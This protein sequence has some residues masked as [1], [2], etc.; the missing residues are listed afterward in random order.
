MWKKTN[1]LRLMSQSSFFYDVFPHF[2]LILSKSSLSAVVFTS[3][4]KGIRFSYDP[5]STPH[6]LQGRLLSTIFEEPI[7]IVSSCSPHLVA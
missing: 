1:Q 5:T 4:I 3:K 2:L 7:D 6:S